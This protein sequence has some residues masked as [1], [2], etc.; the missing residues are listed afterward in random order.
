MNGACCLTAPATSCWDS[1]RA[2]SAGPF[3]WRYPAAPRGRSRRLWTNIVFW[4]SGKPARSVRPGATL[5]MLWSDS[6]PSEPVICCMIRVSRP[7]S[8]VSVVGIFVNPPVTCG[9]DVAPNCEEG[10]DACDVINGLHRLVFRSRRRLQR[11]EVPL[12]R[13]SLRL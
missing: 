2:G 10:C 3:C 12:H 5:G 13:S 4:D 7:F 6:S 1:E 8:E 11:V 9:S